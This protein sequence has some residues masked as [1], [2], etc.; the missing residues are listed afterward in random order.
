MLS[1]VDDVS[2]VRRFS[3]KG[4]VFELDSL[5]AV[6]WLTVVQWRGSLVEV[7]VDVA[8]VGDDAADA[9]DA[10]IDAIG[11]VGAVDVA[12]SADAVDAMLLCLFEYPTS[13]V[14]L[15]HFLIDY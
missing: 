6:T 1:T 2:V 15:L 4:S 9:V 14:G 3:G 11:A 7:D 10:A 13:S 12:D 5:E 8:M